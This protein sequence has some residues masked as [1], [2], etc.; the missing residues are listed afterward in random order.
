M[1]KL[2]VV[3]AIVAIMTTSVLA[4]GGT[5][6]SLFEITDKNKI[7]LCNKEAPTWTCIEGDPEGEVVYQ[8]VGDK[9]KMD[10]SVENLECN[11][12]PTMKYQLTVSAPPTAPDDASPKIGGVCDLPGAA[13]AGFDVA[14]ECALEWD[15]DGTGFLNFEMEGVPVK[16][17]ANPVCKYERVYECKE[18]CYT[19]WGRERCY[20]R[21][22]YTYQ[23]VCTGGDE[24]CTLSGHL[25]SRTPNRSLRGRQVH[26]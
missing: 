19:W 17:S 26:R 21:C 9:L 15:S 25:R 20:N 12:D 22:G 14:W 2:L 6:K 10:V 11:G 3:L 7:E 16:V 23:K 24:S 8:V 5:Y 4:L 1:K 13:A 18:R